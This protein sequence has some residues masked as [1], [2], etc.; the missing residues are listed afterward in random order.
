MSA[1]LIYYVYAYLRKDGTPFYIGKGYGRRA[2][3]KHRKTLPKPHQIAF[4]ETNLTELGSLAIERRMI[5]WYGRKDL[6]TGIL[7][8]R[9]DGGDGARQGPITRAK[10]SKAAKKRSQTPEGR[11]N[12][13]KL[14]SW[15]SIP[16]NREKKR[17]I[18]LANG[19]RPPSQKGKRYWNNGFINKMSAECPEGFWAGRLKAHS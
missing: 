12:M 3:E 13:R 5:H 6:G 10:M 9:S 8:N 18:S 7:L 17:Q 2:Y 11:E 1:E 15:N 16:E 4:L 14:A 19:S